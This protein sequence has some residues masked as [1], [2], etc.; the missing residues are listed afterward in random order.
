MRCQARD[1]TVLESNIQR[2]DDTVRSELS[3]PVAHRFRVGNS[4]ATNNDP[5]NASV[6]PG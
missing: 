4:G 6:E 2:K 1:F 3:T 5:C